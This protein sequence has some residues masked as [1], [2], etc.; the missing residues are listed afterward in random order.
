MVVAVRLP[1]WRGRLAV[2]AGAM[3]FAPASLLAAQQGP[4]RL[5][6]VV[7]G[8][9]HRAAIF[10]SQD[11]SWVVAGEGNTVG[12]YT[13]LHIIPGGTEVAGPDDRRLLVPAPATASASVPPGGPEQCLAQPGRCGQPIRSD[14]ITDFSDRNDTAGI[15]RGGPGT[16]ARMAPDRRH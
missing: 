14:A 5:A 6:G 3:A 12:G 9:N 16:Q 2:L 13:V 8:P 1:P 7:V 10:T 11:G 15:G 4:P